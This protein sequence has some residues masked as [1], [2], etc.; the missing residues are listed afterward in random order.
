MAHA[1]MRHIGIAGISAEGAALAYK[2][3]VHEASRRLGPYTHP[4]I[5]LHAFPFSFY[6]E[7]SPEERD[8]VWCDLLAR[9]VEKLANAGAE[10]FICTSNTNHIVY[11][12]LIAEN[13]LPIPWLHIA[14]PV[15]EVAIE[16]GYKKLALLGTTVTMNSQIYEPTLAKSGISVTVPSDLQMQTINSI[17]YEQLVRGIFVEEST[18]KLLEIIQSL[19]AQKCDAVILGCTELPLVITEENSTLPT[20]DSTRLLGLAAVSEALRASEVPGYFRSHAQSGC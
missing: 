1:T 11:D 7:C 16:R 14:H 18:A 9:S 2:T 19:K 12:R 3:I 15:R 13:R 6:R 4:E 8:E 5:T 10:F 20:L 17:I